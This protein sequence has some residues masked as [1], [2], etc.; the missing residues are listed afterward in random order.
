MQQSSVFPRLALVLAFALAACLCGCRRDSPE[1]AVRK[2]IEAM[3]AAIDAR[4]ARALDELLADDFI[5]NEGIDRRGAKQLAAGVFLRYRSIGAKIGPVTVELRGDADAV[6]RFSIFA[7]GGDGGL[8]P[9]NGQVYRVETGWR[10]VD[11]EWKLLN[12]SWTPS[13]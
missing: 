11:G 4:D 12:A 8:L 7:I 5:G 1:Q 3:Q 2:R 10:R 13:M 9:E 6:A